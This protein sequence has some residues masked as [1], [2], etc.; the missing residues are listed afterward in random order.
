MSEVVID[1]LKAVAP[2]IGWTTLGAVLGILV[3]YR[4]DLGKSR[5]LQRESDIRRE[6]ADLVPL[7]KDAIFECAHIDQPQYAWRH[8]HCQKIGAL[9]P[10]FSTFLK[11]RR[12]TA[13]D[14]AWY[15]CC[16]TQDAELLDK[17]QGPFMD[18]SSPELKAAQKLITSRLQAVLDCVERA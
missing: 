13:F 16:Q 11:G 12:Q 6:R 5:I 9:A 18:A 3:V 17:N 15:K 2:P 1:T 7:L 8:R 4:L 10:R 14:A